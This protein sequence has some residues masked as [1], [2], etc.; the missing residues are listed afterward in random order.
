MQRNNA[1]PPLNSLIKKIFKPQSYSNTLTWELKRIHQQ[2]FDIIL[3]DRY[4]SEKEDSKIDKNTPTIISRKITDIEQLLSDSTITFKH[5]MEPNRQTFICDKITNYLTTNNIIPLTKT[6][7]IIDIGGGNG[8][9][10]TYFGEKFKIP[11]E[12]LICVEKESDVMT[13][14]EFQYEFDNKSITYELCGAELPFATTPECVDIII[15]MVS[16]HHMTDEYVSTLIPRMAELLKKGGILLLK[17]HDCSSPEISEIIDWEH[18]LYTIVETDFGPN[19]IHA[20]EYLDGFVG[21]YKSKAH[22]QTLFQNAGLTMC[23]SFTNIFD[24]IFDNVKNKT[25]SQLYWQ[26]FCK[27]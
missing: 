19:L 2:I 17:E 24:P 15:C 7:K 26:M 25:P 22:Y 20:K 9:V 16:L 27:N 14:L 11:K 18:H 12:N 10:L 6:S 3:F 4:Y 13:N 5:T 21:N 8:N 23:Q 1:Q